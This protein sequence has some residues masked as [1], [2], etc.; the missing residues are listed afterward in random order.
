MIKTAARKRQLDWTLTQRKRRFMIPAMFQRRPAPQ[1][2]DLTSILMVGAL[3]QG[4]TLHIV[5]KAILDF[6]LEVADEN[7]LKPSKTGDLSL[8]DLGMGHDYVARPSHASLVIFHFVYCGLKVKSNERSTKQSPLILS[9]EKTWSDPL[10]ESRP[11]YVINYTDRV[12]C[13]PHNHIARAGYRM[14]DH[15][16]DPQGWVNHAV[17]FKKTP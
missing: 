17:L 11:D 3:M 14:I 9:G 5:D 16:P 12:T 7:G 6:G 1:P 15:R 2:I 13:I 4:D 8:C 10:R